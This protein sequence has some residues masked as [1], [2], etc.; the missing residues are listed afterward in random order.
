MRFRN[1]IKSVRQHV[2]FVSSVHH[3][4]NVLSDSFATDFTALEKVWK[5]HHSSE[6]NDF[7]FQCF[8]KESNCFSYAV[9]LMTHANHFGMTGSQDL[10]AAIMRALQQ[11]QASNG[12]RQQPTAQLQSEALRAS[13]SSKNRF[14]VQLVCDVFRINNQ[15][16]FIDDIIETCVS[17]RNYMEA[18]VCILVLKIQEKYPVEKVLLPLIFEGSVNLAIMYI[19]ENKDMAMKL[20]KALDDYL[21]PGKQSVQKDKLVYRRLSSLLTKFEIPP[22]TCPNLIAI[23]SKSTLNFLMQKR[24][25]ENAI[26][27]SSWEEMTVELLRD[28]P[29]LHRKLLR[30]LVGVQDFDTAVKMASTFNIPF[31]EW[32]P[33][34]KN[35]ETNGELPSSSHNSKNPQHMEISE[36]SLGETEHL[37]LSLDKSCLK[38]IETAEEFE[39]CLSTISE[40][41]SIV[42]FDSEW[43][44][45]FG[46]SRARLALMQLAVEDKVYLL[47]FVALRSCFKKSH[48]DNLIVNFFGNEKILKLGCGLT[49][50]V[51]VLVRNYEGTVGVPLKFSR[52]LDMGIFVQKFHSVC[53]D[54]FQSEGGKAFY[55]NNT[56]GLSKICA[57][58]LGTPLK[59]DKWFSNWEM[60]PLDDSQ[61][62][63][64]ALDAYCLLQIFDKLQ[65]LAEEKNLNFENILLESI[66]QSEEAPKLIYDPKRRR[67]KWSKC[68][69]GFEI[70]PVTHVKEFKILLDPKL[71]SLG[72]GLKN[73]GVDVTFM[74]DSAECSNVIELAKAENR[75]ILASSLL[76]KQ[77][78]ESRNERICFEI[79]EDFTDDQSSV[80]YVFQQFNVRFQAGDIS[81]IGGVNQTS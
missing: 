14:L 54:I 78:T 34:L 4:E 47:D 9:Y 8:E 25:S 73:Y 2:R 68:K 52:L 51:E 29:S 40:N 57:Y 41:Y 11:W 60:R 1:G 31:D 76:Y 7:L 61:L 49:S 10:I 50:D 35:F 33:A 45:G 75:L 59:K 22:E 36:M 48:W 63:Y 26:T 16:D 71:E 74:K 58:V 38:Y 79:S 39:D 44:A 53:P 15:C 66:Q 67:T 81:Y 6:I 70:L 37:S 62:H 23:R 56:L 30:K 42:G 64:A 21:L 3:P 20:I 13:L 65:E 77:L 12:A 27:H 17:R 72:K 55:S 69:E 18:A 32:P 5:Q 28:S 46:L 19:G 24:Y 43:K 80:A